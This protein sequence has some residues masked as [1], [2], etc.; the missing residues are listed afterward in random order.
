M[1]YGFINAQQQWN[2]KIPGD[3]S[4]VSV[5]AQPI[6]YNDINVTTI[7]QNAS[8]VGLYAAQQIIKVIK[9]PEAT[10]Q[11]IYLPPEFHEG[12]TVARLTNVCF[13]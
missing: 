2:R 7:T 12:N 8:V 3:I 10:P 9:D 6:R 5:A 11:K 4:I 1:T 13:K